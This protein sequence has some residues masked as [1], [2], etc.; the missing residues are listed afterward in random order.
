MPMPSPATSSH[1]PWRTTSPR[2]FAGAAPSASRIATSRV[3]WETGVREHTM[4]TDRGEHQSKD[5]ECSKERRCQPRGHG[6]KCHVRLERSDV[7]QRQ[8][9]VE[10][11]DGRT[12]T[13][14]KHRRVF[15]RAHV[16][17]HLRRHIRPAGMY[18]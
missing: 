6:R 4:Q 11:A 1:M 18:M 13:R 3:R 15:I 12:D 9:R 16:E 8:V 17:H 14:H 7:E 5:A 2:T 10:C